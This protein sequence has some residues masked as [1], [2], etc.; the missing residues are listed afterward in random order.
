MLAPE[1][2]RGPCPP[3]SSCSTLSALASSLS[4]SGSTENQVAGTKIL[5]LP[6]NT[7]LLIQ[8]TEGS[9]EVTLTPIRL[10]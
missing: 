6:L 9:L 8:R 10:K 5:S 3:Q 1:L 2:P 4:G 7:S